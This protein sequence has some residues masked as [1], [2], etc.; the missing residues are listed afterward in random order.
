MRRNAHV[1]RKS[2]QVPLVKGISTAFCD[3]LKARLVEYSDGVLSAELV[4]DERHLDLGMAIRKAVN[5]GIGCCVVMSAP[6]LRQADGNSPDDTRYNVD[7]EVAIM[8][9]AALSP[10]VDSVTLSESIFR[11]LAATHFELRTEFPPNVRA[12]A[13]NHTLNATKWLHQFTIT[14]TLTI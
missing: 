10:N 13:L 8:H 3:W 7:V 14:Y 12:D 9:N 4:Y 1:R 11:R 6:S 2:K 5:G